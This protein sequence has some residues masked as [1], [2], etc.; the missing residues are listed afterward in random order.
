MP[1]IYSVLPSYRHVIVQSSSVEHVPMGGAFALLSGE[2]SNRHEGR[3]EESARHRRGAVPATVHD[4]TVFVGTGAPAPMSSPSA[5]LESPGTAASASEG[6]VFL[7]LGN[8]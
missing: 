7:R 1:G 6:Y 8:H 4:C 2:A 5:A 3:D